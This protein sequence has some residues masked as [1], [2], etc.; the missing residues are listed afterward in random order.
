MGGTFQWIKYVWKL[1]VLLML[2]IIAFSYAMFQGGFVSWFLLYSF[3]PF[4]FY[5]IFLTFYSL[6]D[7]SIER[8]LTRWEYYANEA[9]IVKITLKRDRAF[10]LLFIIIE[11]C[12]SEALGKAVQENKYKVILFPGFK[13]EWIYEYKIS[14]LPRGEHHLQ[15]VRIFTSDF[16]GLIEKEKRFELS[17]MILV[18]PAYEKLI[19]ESGY[20]YEQGIRSS[21]NVTPTEVSM[22]GGIREYQP[23]D[24]LS[25]INWKASAKREGMVT[26]EFEQLQSDDMVIVMDCIKDP[27]FE[28]I[29]SFTASL[30]QAVLQTGSHIGF[31]A[32]DND[33]RVIPIQGGAVC[34]QLLFYSLA[35]VKDDA[36][37]AFDRVL[38]TDSFLLQHKVSYV[39]VTAQLTSQLIEAASRLTARRCPVSIF[40]IKDT[41]EAITAFEQATKLTAH[42]YGI[43]VTFVYK[44]RFSAGPLEVSR[45]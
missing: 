41:G 11:D 8:S 40:I 23:G 2:M 15:A 14:K 17:E 33:R 4:F 19:F 1:F 24:R 45:G 26:K 44:E 42:K 10:P 6:E 43:K 32:I 35:K 25:W 34:R 18:H 20:N 27:H 37:V 13:K 38:S 7:F 16:L 12:L 22:V 9:L 28:M 31:L 21:N 5:A 30:G 36:P 3:L 39:L 29:V